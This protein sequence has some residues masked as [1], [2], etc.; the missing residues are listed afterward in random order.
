MLHLVPVLD[1]HLQDQP[2]PVDGHNPPDDVHGRQHLD[3]TDNELSLAPLF[4][5]ANAGTNHG[6]SAGKDDIEDEA[7]VGPDST[8][9]GER[10]DQ[11]PQLRILLPIHRNRLLRVVDTLFGERIGSGLIVCST[12]VIVVLLGLADSSGVVGGHLSLFSHRAAHS[13][14]HSA[15]TGTASV[16]KVSVIKVL[17]HFS[18]VKMIVLIIKRSLSN[19]SNII[20][21]MNT[22]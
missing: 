15:N 16:I 2:A 10:T 11:V 19:N 12:S 5:V 3:N 1:S 20:F 18:F 21:K 17:C 13:T 4:R 6:T 14:A 8:Q 9:A 22:F 7:D